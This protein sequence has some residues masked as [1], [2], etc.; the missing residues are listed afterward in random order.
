MKSHREHER[1][2]RG[3]QPRGF[4]R[5][6][7]TVV[8]LPHLVRNQQRNQ[9]LKYTQLY[10]S[11]TLAQK[12]RLH[13]GELSESRSH[14]PQLPN[15]RADEGQEGEHCLEYQHSTHSHFSLVQI[16]HRAS[17]IRKRKTFYMHQLI[18]DSYLKR[19]DIPK[20][21][22]IPQ[23]VPLKVHKEMHQI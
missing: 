14:Q 18:P 7:N 12:Y 17:P 2:F 16:P 11:I 4:L 20:S 22:N 13:I 1:F 5:H 6:T 9:Y 21:T 19:E 8:R 10:N 23:K 15:E 3:R